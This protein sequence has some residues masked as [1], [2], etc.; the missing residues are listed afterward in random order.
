VQRRER[1]S[2]N[3]DGCW[4]IIRLTII[5]VAIR[6]VGASLFFSH[7]MDAIDHERVA[8]PSNRILR[9]TIKLRDWYYYSFL[10]KLLL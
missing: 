3:I 9:W 8:P 2:Q 1:Q 6:V 7:A 5:R 4:A 10:T